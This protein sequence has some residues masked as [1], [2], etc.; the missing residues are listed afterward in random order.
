MREASEK[1]EGRIS[2]PIAFGSGLEL[3]KRRL[4]RHR[5]SASEL[6]QRRSH[7][8]VARTLVTSVCAAHPFPSRR[9]GDL[10]NRSL[11]SPQRPLKLPGQ[12][13]PIIEKSSRSS[14]D[15]LLNRYEN[16]Y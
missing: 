13:R 16:G 14:R 6:A 10:T 9:S 12:L 8:V 2:A 5:S 3:S 4:P 1:I 11:V 7:G 15:G